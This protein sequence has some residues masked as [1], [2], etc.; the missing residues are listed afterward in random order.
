MTRANP[1]PEREFQRTIVDLLDT[2]GYAVDHTYPLRT[3][4][5]W[6]TG[7]TLVGKPDLLAIRPPRILAIEV[8]GE[9]TRV[10]PEQIACLSLFAEVPCA[11]AWLIRPSDP[12]SDLVAWVR[13][14]KLAP[15]TFGFDPITVGEARRVLREARRR[16]AAR[17]DAPPLGKRSRRG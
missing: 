2:F 15:A 16:K 12:W 5:G 7:S 1:T 3:Q 8:K 13:R 6:R 10:E 4:H 14:P 9:H 17:R 11:R